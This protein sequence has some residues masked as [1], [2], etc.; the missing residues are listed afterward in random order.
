MKWL[1]QFR[2]TQTEKRG[3]LVLVVITNLVVVW[4]VW[5]RLSPSAVPVQNSTLLEDIK[6]W[7]AEQRELLRVPHR[8]D[9]NAISEQFIRSLKL[10]KYTKDNWLKFRAYRQFKTREDVLGIYGMD[11]LWY[12]VN[13][14][15]I[16]I[17]ANNNRDT[18]THDPEPIQLVYF[19]PNSASRADFL[20][21]GFPEWLAERIIKYRDKGGHFDTSADLL[22]IYDFP[23]ELYK[24][25]EPFIQINEIDEPKK[26]DKPVEEDIQMVELNS[27]DSA[28]FTKIRGIG[29]VFASRMVQYRDRLGGFAN[30]TQLLEVYGIDEAKLAEIEGRIK[31][32][33]SLI[34]KLNVNTLAFK[35]LLRHPYLDFDQVKS[36]VNYRETIGPHQKIT[37]L[38][39]LEGFSEKDIERLKPYLTV[40]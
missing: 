6:V 10:P 32:N 26:A 13:A 36:I 1:D 3:F 21:L 19:D 11:T 23:E 5:L 2:L 4:Y 15:S 14:D 22:N 12:E 8:F 16:V 17:S 39:H 38:I 7:E 20:K 28:S 29:P 18:P 30:K 9:P 24:R 31:I 34:L 33:P 25:I 35:Q 37:D 27:A 40:Q